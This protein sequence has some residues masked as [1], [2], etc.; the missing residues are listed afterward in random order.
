[1]DLSCLGSVIEIWLQSW[2]CRFLTCRHSL[3]FALSIFYFVR[4]FPFSFCFYWRK[5]DLKN[6][7][8]LRWCKNNYYSQNLKALAQTP[9]IRRDKDLF[10]HRLESVKICQWKKLYA[11]LDQCVRRKALLTK[12]KEGVLTKSQ[13]LESVGGIAR[14]PGGK[15]KIE[16]IAVRYG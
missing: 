9:P 10:W 15:I 14:I 4:K 8:S 7:R 11:S 12:W 16:T 6:W 3:P 5:V 1:M 2:L 13:A